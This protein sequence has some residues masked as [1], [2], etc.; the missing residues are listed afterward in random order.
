MSNV[1]SWLRG[2]R[3]TELVELADEAGLKDYESLKK[4]DLEVKLDEFL[5][6]NETSLSKRSRFNPF[7]T[8]SGTAGSPV[9][10]EAPGTVNAVA[11]SDGESKATKARSRRVTKVADEISDTLA[12][13]T[14][15]PRAN[16]ALARNVP[17]PP[18]PA[19]VADAIDRRT[20]VL[21]SKMSDVWDHYGVV[22]R[23]EDLR[24]SL[25][26]VA[27]IE[28]IVLAVEAFGLR[29]EVLPLRYA[30]TIPAVATLRTS[31]VNVFLPDMFFLLTA[32]FWS[33]FTLWFLTSIAVPLLFAY[34]FNLTLKHK[35]THGHARAQLTKASHVFDPLTF[36]LAKA[37]TA[38]LVYSQEV[39]FGGLLGYE[40]VDRVRQAI[41]GGTEGIL[42]GAA[43]GAVTSLYDA[44]LKK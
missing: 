16:L 35:S 13:A 17:L 21:R 40:T 4:A 12:M 10:R 7:Y 20:A 27:S 5:R 34:F 26:S 25:S 19:V 11:T 18:S 28:T 42:I 3:K 2:Q 36:N 22:E 1:S 14:R 41:P 8:R 6:A 44:A 9:K 23:A 39:K 24:E 29:S 30:F 43:V 31:D 38:F 33:P 32:S 37:L 15:T